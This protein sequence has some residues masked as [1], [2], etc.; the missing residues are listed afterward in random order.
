M[1]KKNDL[2]NEIVRFNSLV[3]FVLFF[4]NELTIKCVVRFGGFMKILEDPKQL[5]A[6]MDCFEILAL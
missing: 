3:F 1:W 5:M 4:L 6:K 2:A